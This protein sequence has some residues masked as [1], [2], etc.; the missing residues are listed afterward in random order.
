MYAHGKGTQLSQKQA[1][2]HSA[3]SGP[4]SVHPG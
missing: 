1:L 2:E 4:L 3:G